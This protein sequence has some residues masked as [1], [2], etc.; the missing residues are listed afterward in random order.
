MHQ[1]NLEIVPDLV[2]L[3]LR[4]KSLEIQLLNQKKVASFPRVRTLDEFLQE[5]F[6]D[7]SYAGEQKQQIKFIL[8]S[9][10]EEF[11]WGNLVKKNNKFELNYAFEFGAKARHAYHLATKIFYDIKNSSRLNEDQ[12]N[13]FQ[14]F[15]QYQI[16]LKNNEIVDT[17]LLLQDFTTY[18]G[19]KKFQVLGFDLPLPLEK[20]IVSLAE[21]VQPNNICKSDYSLFEFSSFEDE[22][23]E[24]FRWAEAFIEKGLEARIAIVVDKQDLE[25]ATIIG[26]HMKIN[27]YSL[28][29]QEKISKQS[30]V[31]LPLELFKLDHIFTWEHL[32]YL[33]SNHNLFGASEEFRRRSSFDADFRAS[34]I[35]QISLKDLL[36]YNKLSQSCPLFI[37]FLKR[38]NQF[39]YQRQGKKL[40]TLWVKVVN[41]F[42]QDINWLSNRANNSLQDKVF[43]SWSSVCDS[44]CSLDALGTGEISFKDFSYHLSRKLEVIEMR[45]ALESSN[46]FVLDPDQVSSV[47][48]THL[49]LSGMSSGKP[50]LN[51][52]ISNLLPLAPQIKA[53]V[54]GVDSMVDFQLRQELFNSLLSNKQEIIISYSSYTKGI[55]NLKSPLVDSDPFIHKTNE[56]IKTKKFLARTIDYENLYGARFNK[57]SQSFGSVSFFADQAACP[58]KGYAI[59]RLGSKA[60]EEPNPGIS[61]KLQGMLVHEVLANLWTNIRSLNNLKSK[62]SDELAR[63]V[64]IN[65]ENVFRRSENLVNCEV[66]IV[67]IEKNRIK[68]LVLYWLEFEKKGENFKVVGIEK[69]IQG[70]IFNT[71][72][73][74]RLD[75]LD[76]LD[77]GS[78]RVIDYKT[79]LFAKGDLEP[80]RIKSPQLYLYSMLVGLDKVENFSV[81]RITANTASLISKFL[82]THDN[83][84]W[85]DDLENLNQEINKGFAARIPKKSEATCNFCDQKLFCRI[86]TF[87][88]SKNDR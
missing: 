24:A 3:K 86:K 68:K 51:N 41:N 66:P 19:E 58:F 78:L 18:F 76:R 29:A 11:L 26:K 77:N 15:N 57:D 83:Q 85:H 39:I 50:R 12:E 38:F 67:D 74:C 22:I 27:F 4:L 88:N 36:T 87:E 14:L 44:L 21:S 75:R 37:K 49:W 72:V 7:R 46:V 61:K 53:M 13:F 62:T 81:A 54:P 56:K 40:F 42:L 17:N 45:Y 9:N 64:M 63:I 70:K 6:W 25:Y 33:L 35:Y 5:S 52:N 48:P 59:H 28:A 8:D 10:Q 20:K 73:S 32:S 55:K 34:G 30:M 65:I 79:G 80:P 16:F 31:R 82:Q 69:K 47:Q 23:Q 60:I 1:E 43:Q 84:V 71:V 2:S